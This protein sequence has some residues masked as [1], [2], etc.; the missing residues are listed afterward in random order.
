VP[1]FYQYEIYLEEYIPGKPGENRLIV[2]TTII[3]PPNSLF[4][5]SNILLDVR[6]VIQNEP[7]LSAWSR[8]NPGE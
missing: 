7:I 8:H 2:L 4:V 6:E 1:F 5:I 3:A